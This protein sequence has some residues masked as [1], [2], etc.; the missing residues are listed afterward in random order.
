MGRSDDTEPATRPGTGE[1][2]LLVDPLPVRRAE[3]AARLE[4]RGLGVLLASDGQVAYEILEKM[5][6]GRLPDLV[7]AELVMP[8]LDG[9]GLVAALKQVVAYAA[10]PVV[11]FSGA[12]SHPPASLE[13]RRNGAAQLV[14]GAIALEDI[15]AAIEG[16]LRI[17]RSL[18]RLAEARAFMT[19]PT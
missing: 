12:A 15:E 6:K 17:Q 13:D 14:R 7:A 1:L 2:L 16:R 10:I 3:L 18:R 5:P 9:H 11:L 19:R 4:G 8:R